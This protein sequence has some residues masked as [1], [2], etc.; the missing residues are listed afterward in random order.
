MV[1]QRQKGIVGA[2]VSHTC[3][4]CQAV[5]PSAQAC[6]AHLHRRHSVINV[7]T[8][9]TNGTVCLWCNTEHHS[10][11]RLKYHLK[12]TP[13][14]VHGLRVVVGPQYEHGTGTKRS[15]PRTH[16]GLPPIRVAGP[17]N[18]TP[19]QRAACLA[20]RVCTAD[21]IDRELLQSVGTRDV[22]KW[23]PDCPQALAVDGHTASGEGD[24]APA[25]PELSAQAP[26]VAG[27]PRV[28][29]RWFSLLPL[30]EVKEDDLHVPSP[31]W[32]GLFASAFAC[33]FPA[34]W[35][36]YWRTWSA[37][38]FQDPWTLD[39]HRAVRTAREASVPAPGLLDRGPPKPLLD[40]LAATVCLRLVCEQ[41]RT[42][43]MAWI[44]GV[45][46]RAGV[47]LLRSLLPTASFHSIW[48]P[49][50]QIFVVASV[51]CPPLLWQPELCALFSTSPQGRS[52]EVRA[53]RSSFVYHTRSLNPG[54]A[55]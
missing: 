28:L 48:T 51:S 12:T 29:V 47:N 14:C 41:L 13:A 39:F 15:G 36:R 52:P 8:R 46:S 38:H 43:G 45:P 42:H 20:G 16:R 30:S 21:E 17:L 40:F 18:A 11:D 53:L 32:P 26:P 7:L 2:A 55:L 10:T 1:T 50:A 19:A 5:F 44:R 33:Q 4:L 9:Y 37:L 22:Y 35:H 3:P 6:A 24:P 54:T 31:L 27:T 34:A 25:L 23:P 49:V